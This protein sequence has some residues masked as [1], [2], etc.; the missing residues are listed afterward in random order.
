MRQLL[1]TWLVAVT[2]LESG[3]EKAVCLK[4]LFVSCIE[5]MFFSCTN[6]TIFSSDGRKSSSE[7]VKLNLDP[8]VF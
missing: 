2:E 4:Q 7:C 3:N 6:M 1:G 5:T 8:P